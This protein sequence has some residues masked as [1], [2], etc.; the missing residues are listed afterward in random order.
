ML[1]LDRYPQQPLSGRSCLPEKLWVYHSRNH[2][3]GKKNSQPFDKSALP[4]ICERSLKKEGDGALVAFKI[5]KSLADKFEKIQKIQT[6]SKTSKTSQDVLEFPDGS[7]FFLLEQ[8]CHEI[9]SSSFQSGTV[10][11]GVTKRPIAPFTASKK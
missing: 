6:M 2:E 11:Y 8:L 5:T 9:V 7:K 4:L 10:V 3:K 1:Y